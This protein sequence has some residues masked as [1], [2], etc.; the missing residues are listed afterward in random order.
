MITAVTLF[1]LL[2]LCTVAL[3]SIDQMLV[4]RPLT[5]FGLGAA[6]PLTFVVANEFAPVRI[7]ARMVAVMATGF[8]VG[9]AS[10]GLLQ[11]EML[12]Y[13]GWQ[14]IFV[15]AACFRWCWAWRCCCSCRNPSVSSRP[16]AAS[17]RKSRP[18]Y[19]R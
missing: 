18:F 3:T 9:A 16:S 17:R 8:A 6:L 5:G 1:G 13:F 14:G 7:R 11:A 4:L 12:P 15:V 2:T 19:G 10:G